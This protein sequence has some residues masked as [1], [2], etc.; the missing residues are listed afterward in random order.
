MILYVR[1][2]VG[3]GTGLDEQGK[4]QFRTEYW[5]K[6]DTPNEIRSLILADLRV[7]C[8]GAPH[9]QNPACLC[10]K[11][12]VDQ[13]KDDPYLWRVSAEWNIRTQDKKD[14]A[15]GQ[16]QPDQRRPVWSY[17]F[18]A[19]Q[20]YALRDLDGVPF[21]DKAGTPFSPPPSLAIF[22]DEVT[23]E[24]YE[25]ALDRAAD[26]GY[27]N[28][29]NSDD[30]DGNAADT[31][32]VSD[33]SAREIFEHGSLWW[34]KTYRILCNPKV[35]IGGE[36]AGGFNPFQVLNAGPRMLQAIDKNAAPIVYKAVPIHRDGFSDGQPCPL[37][38]S[39]QPLLPAA[40]GQAVWDPTKIVW[41]NFRTV[42]RVSY[43]PLNLVRP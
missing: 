42:N 11:V 31:C 22:V 6:S 3:A 30:W 16:K 9:P 20:R 32:L 17:N 14:P 15:D 41:L 13:N 37:D 7:P 33:I 10:S 26:R 27:L 25:P 39:G 24:R 43:S 19:L 29:T 2:I 1:R 18:S 35:R 34:A 8:Y 5:V 23:I 36:P 38:N 4:Q 28:A 40:P 21:V 12:T